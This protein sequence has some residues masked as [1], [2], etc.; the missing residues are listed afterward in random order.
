MPGMAT[1]RAERASTQA[2]AT[3]AGVASSVEA[4]CRRICTSAAFA[5]RRLGLEA[6][7]AAPVISFRQIGGRT[8]V[9]RQESAPQR[10]V[11][12]ESDAELRAG[13]EH[14]LLGIP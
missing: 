6:R 4:I 8:E 13:C 7:M 12:H 11:G 14:S 2:M 5:P 3:C 9:G 10:A 1:T